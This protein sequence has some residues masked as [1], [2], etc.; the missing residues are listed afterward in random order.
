[1]RGSDPFAAY[2]NNGIQIGGGTSGRFYSNDVI[3][4]QGNGFIIIGLGDTWVYNNVIA[5]AANGMYVHHDAS[6][7]RTLVIAH[8]TIVSSRGGT[9]PARGIWVFNDS[10]TIRAENNIVV[11]ATREQAFYLQNPAA[12]W[13]SLANFV[14]TDL[15]APRFVDTTRD[16]YHLRADSVA[17]GHGVNATADGIVFDHD[18]LPRNT[19]TGFDQGAFQIP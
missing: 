10:A 15:T 8:N 18:Y 13:T 1:M 19:T 2:Q 7:G 12:H 16:D 4:A 6:V 9:D 17:G 11:N 14:T 5:R 3:D